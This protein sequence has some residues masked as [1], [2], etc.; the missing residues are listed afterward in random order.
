MVRIKIFDEEATIDGYKWQAKNKSIL[1]MLNSFLSPF[2]T[3]PSDPHPDLTVAQEVID[4]V[5]G[6]ILH[7]DPAEYVE[8][9]IY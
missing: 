8:G 2:G 3:S 1:A 6:E 7:A 9:R 4:T 5:N